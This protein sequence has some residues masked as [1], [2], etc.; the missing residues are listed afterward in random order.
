MGRKKESGMESLGGIKIHF[1]KPGTISVVWFENNFLSWFNLAFF[2]LIFSILLHGKLSSLNKIWPQF[3]KESITLSTLNG[4]DF[5]K[6]LRTP[7]KK[8]DEFA[9]DTDVTTQIGILLHLREN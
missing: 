3:S 2:P 1:F 4:F 8:T 9:Q 5:L 6:Y 7:N